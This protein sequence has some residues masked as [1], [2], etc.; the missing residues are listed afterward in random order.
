[1]KKLIAGLLTRWA[2]VLLACGA[3]PCCQAMSVDYSSGSSSGDYSSGSSSGEFSS[4]SSGV[5]FDRKK[6]QDSLDKACSVLSEKEKEILVKKATETLNKKVKYCSKDLKGFLLDFVEVFDRKSPEELKDLPKDF[7][8]R[9]ACDIAGIDFE[10]FDDD[11]YR[12]VY[13]CS[14]HD[15]LPENIE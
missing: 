12:E 7:N 2:V 4:G 1:M 14:I 8:W 9:I 15:E 6:L 13:D 5:P 3:V 10:K 11:V